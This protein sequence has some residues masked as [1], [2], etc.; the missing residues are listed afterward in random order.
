M[1]T[2]SKNEGSRQVL[3]DPQFAIE[4]RDL[5][6]FLGEFG[7]H[8]GRYIPRYPNDWT[9][10]FKAH[11]DELSL[12]EKQPVKRKS[13][14]QR[15]HQEVPLCT[16]PIGWHWESEQSWA[17]NVEKVLPED[18]EAIVVGQALDPTPF[19]AWGEA[20]DEI[21]E[22]RRRSWPYHGTI[23][24]YVQFCRPLLVN[25]P[26]A[27][28]ID[29]YLDPFE[30]VW[31]ELIRALFDIAKGSRCYSIELI[32]HRSACAKDERP[33]KAPPLPFS[34]ID[35]RFQRTYRDLVPKDRSLKLHLVDEGSFQGETLHLHDRFFMTTHGSLQF[36]Q[37]FVIGSKKSPKQNAFVTERDH[38]VQLKKTYID[39]VARFRERLPRVAGIPYPIDV[40]T[41]VIS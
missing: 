34:E 32:T 41:M 4:W 40:N 8:N 14:M 6:D 35:G 33:D 31:E 10:R 29:P 19:T 23:N 38:H 3:V 24:E 9:A 13:L 2:S 30:D 37:G 11:V 12:A 26:S 28:L 17:H 27:Y 25:S 36:G 39:G 15:I 18:S 5:S 20:L 16:V 1:V 22:S 21:R 7:P